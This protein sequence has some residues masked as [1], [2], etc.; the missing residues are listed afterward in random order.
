MIYVD[1]ERIALLPFTNVMEKIIE[2]SFIK[3][4]S[5][6]DFDADVWQKT[7]KAQINHYWSGAKA[8]HERS[9]TAQM[10]WTQDFLYVR[11]DC[12]QYESMVKNQH[13]QVEF[14]TAELWENDVCELFIA[15]E[16][17]AP[18]SYFEFEIAPTGEWLDYKI[19]Q[20]SDR[21]ETDTTFDA[22]MKTAIKTNV[23]GFAAIFSVP[24]ESF[25]K[26]PRIGEEWRG[27]FFRCIGAGEERGYL[28]WQ[29]TRT[30]NP[31]FH[32]PQVFGI[33]KFE[34]SNE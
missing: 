5:L 20:L 21:R 18:E 32:V 28:T 19:R 30:E 8:P 33:F 14:E 34:N 17:A 25:G 4:L 3:N 11:F 7:Q 10:A 6:M 31:N 22:G 24:F 16:A 2:V 13:P 26:R 9:A 29:P 1:S 15:P 12:Q 27:N 23:N